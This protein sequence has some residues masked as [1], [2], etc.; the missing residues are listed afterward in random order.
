VQ[1]VVRCYQGR[2]VHSTTL[3]RIADAADELGLPI[4][5]AASPRAP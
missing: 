2:R 3:I 1:T 5:P 4:P